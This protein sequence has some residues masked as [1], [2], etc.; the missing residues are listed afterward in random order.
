MTAAPDQDPLIVALLDHGARLDLSDLLT[1]LA[2]S[3]ALA[4]ASDDPE[5][6]CRTAE[7]AAAR[8]PDPCASAAC[9][10]VGIW[11]AHRTGWATRRMPEA[12]IR[13]RDVLLALTPRLRGHAAAFPPLADLWLANA[14]MD[15]G[16][17]S[18]LDACLAAS[19]GSQLRALLETRRAVD[20][21]R[22]GELHGC[23]RPESMS[24]ARWQA[25]HWINAVEA[26]D[27]DRIGQAGQALTALADADGNRDL[28]AMLL[29]YAAF[30]A[31]SAAILARQPPPDAEAV[32]APLLAGRAGF[33]G[34]P[35]R[36]ADDVRCLAAIAA[37]RSD[38]VVNRIA[39]D[40]G[41]LLGGSSMAALMPVRAAFALGDQG[42]ASDHLGLR[43]QQ[44]IDGPA[45]GVHRARLLLAEGDG[46]GAR[47]E[48]VQAVHAAERLGMVGRIAHELRLVGGLDADALPLLLS[49]RLNADAA[50]A[51]PADIAQLAGRSAHAAAVRAAVAAAAGSSAPVLIQGP[52]G[53]GKDAVAEAIHAQSSRAHLP[54]AVLDCAGAADADLE[55]R[56]CGSGRLAGLAE[57]CRG[58]TL[59]V[60]EVTAAGP[61]TQHALHRLAVRGEIIATDGSQRRFTACRLILLSSADTAAEAQAGRLL[62]DLHVVV[63][64]QAI[65]LLP[66]MERADDLVPVAMAMVDPERNGA[67][68][69]S[70]ELATHLRCRSWAGGFAELRRLCDR[71]LRA[72]PDAGVL[73][74]ADFM[75]AVAASDPPPAPAPAAAERATRGRAGSVGT[76]PSRQRR[77][78]RLA[79]LL[80]LHRRLTRNDI[81][82]LMECAP[83]TATIDLRFL[84]SQGLARK[85]TPSKSPR[86]HYFVW[87]GPI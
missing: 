13:L 14:R 25:L 8:C 56:L 20:Q 82:R 85:V 41:A 42:L 51:R 54:F 70:S 1:S 38:P 52:N 17:G 71:M 48:L 27:R 77:R 60:R 66:I 84:I 5:D 46:D 61:R 75:A 86:S 65:R 4:T 39:G 79:D 35:D 18:L 68:V 87:N 74:L 26:V 16:R 76:G 63:R 19:P 7:V 28:R 44:G 11:H 59:I 24:E 9:L 49:S 22:R 33:T 6:I 81:V 55:H 32:L 23:T 50:V 10:L 69:L 30:A 67:R 73:T 45:D 21:A 31:V 57:G 64:Q 36:M 58:G 53:C 34:K 83:E 3:S 62:R 15:P 40:R 12:A 80:R 43:R 2:G 29:W 37:G 47:N 78:G 72:R